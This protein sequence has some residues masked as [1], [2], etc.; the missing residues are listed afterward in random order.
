MVL[1]ADHL[2]SGFIG[3]QWSGQEEKP[4]LI[5]FLMFFYLEVFKN[6]VLVTKKRSFKRC[7]GVQ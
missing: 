1:E 6:K 7:S 5:P 3:E 4:G 2:D